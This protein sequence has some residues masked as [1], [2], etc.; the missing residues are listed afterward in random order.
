MFGSF[1]NA[2]LANQFHG[3]A[4][5]FETMD[6]LA[7]PPYAISLQDA[8]QAKLASIDTSQSL[9]LKQ[10]VLLKQYEWDLTLLG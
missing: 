5:D 9:E 1:F 7:N 4:D 8:V 10:F 2:A 3:E 6:V